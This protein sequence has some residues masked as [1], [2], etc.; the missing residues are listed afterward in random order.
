[1]HIRRAGFPFMAQATPVQG[2]MIRMLVWIAIVPVLISSTAALAAPADERCLTCHSM[3]GLSKTL[4]D[5]DKLSLHIAADEW[6]D[7]VHSMMGCNMCHRDVD[8]AKH[9]SMA[10]ISSARDY[11]LEKAGVC[12]TC[13]AAQFDLY[14]GSVHASLVETGDEEAPVCSSCHDVHAQK[15]VATYDPTSGEPCKRCHEGIFDAYASSMHGQARIDKGEIQAPICAD[16][17]QV[18]DV[19]AVALGDQIKNACLGCHDDARMAHD[20]WLPNSSLHLEMVSCPACH[21]PMAERSVDLRMH[22]SESGEL[23]TDSDSAT[24]FEDQA[25][26][27]DSGGDGLGPMEL[28]EM[29]HESDREGSGNGITLKGRLEVSN[30]VQAHQL[31][32]KIDAVRDC[33]T[34][35]QSGATPYENVTVSVAADDGRRIRY[36]AEDE[37]LTSAVSVDAVGGF[38]TAGGTR[39]KLLDI[40]VVLA[41]VGGLAIPATHMAVRKYFKNKS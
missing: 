38:Y 21:S 7:S 13:H 30:G 1:M 41:I 20:E 25:L 15:K 32:L 26:A 2:L 24:R 33:A 4:G 19:K 10:S 36:E 28:R 16:C 18:H 29:V 27:I 5:G 35:H 12:R 31:A 23:I 11:A 34:C 37:T 39:I 14:E 22:D 6:S 9:P 3:A 40:L 8:P 17:H